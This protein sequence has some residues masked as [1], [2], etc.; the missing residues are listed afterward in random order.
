M[1]G[2]L[3]LIGG[4]AST[5]Y[6]GIKSANA[7]NAQ[8]KLIADQAAR[9]DAWYNKNYYE[10]YMDSREA[11]AA[12]KRV[13]DTMRR[14]TQQARA[15]AAIAGE[16]PESVA[17]AE[18]R[19]QEMMGDV[20][21]RLAERSD[22][23]KQSVDAQRNAND[24]RTLQLRAEQ[25]QMDEAGGSAL[26]N[27]GMGLIGSA[28]SYGMGTKADAATKAGEGTA[29]GTTDATSG[30]VDASKDVV[31][32]DVPADDTYLGNIIKHA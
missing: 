29:S 11:Q 18:Q 9:N 12:M 19:N 1:L 28:L 32:T 22:A 20:V 24:N 2:A 5:A 6:G 7:A 10:N 23:R 17:A 27:S 16:T 8:K 4:L 14:R 13:E 15:N 3:A 30:T 25:K 26:M 21:S 31:Q